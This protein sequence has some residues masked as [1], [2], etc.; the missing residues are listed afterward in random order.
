MIVVKIGG[1]IADRCDGL[2]EE[3]AGRDDVVLVHGFGPQ[4]TRRC[5]ELGV[6]PRTICSPSG[7]TSRFTDHHVIQAMRQ[8][9][10]DVGADLA[11]RLEGLGRSVDHLGIQTPLVWGQAKPV[12]RHATGDGRVLLVRG[13]R[14]GRVGT[15]EPTPVREALAAGQLPVVTPMA[16]D[17]EGWLSVDGDRAAAALAAALDAEALVLLTDVPGFLADPED[18]TSRLDR[19]DAGKVEALLGQDA[20][21]GMVRKL[22][23]CQ[24][25]LEG[26]VPRALIG[27]GLQPE[28]VDRAL[29][30]DAT[31]VV[32]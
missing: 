25:A 10:H 21:G 24:E 13:N 2:L 23:A 11:T 17:G 30:G 1:S 32:G 18:P 19:L 3:L 26:E 8:A 6:E 15:V 16:M 28:P 4:T 12:L 7:V 29:A 27:S 20:S 5:R 31:E 9:A 14:S 22:V